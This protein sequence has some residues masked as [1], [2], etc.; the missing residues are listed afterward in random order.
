MPEGINFL[1]WVQIS[2]ILFLDFRNKLAREHLCLNQSV[3]YTC[4]S[5]EFLKSIYVNPTSNRSHGKCVSETMECEWLGNPLITCPSPILPKI[6]IAII[7]GNDLLWYCKVSS[8]KSVITSNTKLMLKTSHLRKLIYAWK[9]NPTP[10][11]IVVGHYTKLT[12]KIISTSIW[13]SINIHL[14]VLP[15]SPLLQVERMSVW[16]NL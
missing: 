6:L 14:Q 9:Q 2:L 11:H 7:K 13:M 3:L 8:V 15:G 12:M 1:N 10:I 5:H 16:R 4:M